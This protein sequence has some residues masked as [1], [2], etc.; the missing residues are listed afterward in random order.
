M[1][2][3]IALSYAHTDCDVF[4]ELAEAALSL[5]HRGQDSCGFATSTLNGC[6]SRTSGGGLVKD[7]VMANRRPMKGHVGV[8]HRRQPLVAR[9]P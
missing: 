5:Q 3:I 1:C 8:G 9:G 4:G 7:V 6:T 2:G